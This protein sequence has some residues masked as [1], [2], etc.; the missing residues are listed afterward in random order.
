MI[1]DYFLIQNCVGTEK[2]MLEK[3]QTN[4]EAN[5]MGMPKSLYLNTK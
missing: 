4:D 3:A 1:S 2:R 5:E